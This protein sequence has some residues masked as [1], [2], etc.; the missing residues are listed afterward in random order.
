MNIEN[1]SGVPTSIKKAIDT[2][3]VETLSVNTIEDFIDP[4]LTPEEKLKKIALFEKISQQGGGHGAPLEIN[5]L[6]PD[7]SSPSL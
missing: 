4:S 2:T 6:A 7:N 1:I 5:E 3:P